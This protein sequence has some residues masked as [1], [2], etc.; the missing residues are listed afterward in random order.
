MCLKKNLV[1][2]Y[3]FDYGS[4]LSSLSL[5]SHTQTQGVLVAASEMLKQRYGFVHTVLQ[6]EKYQDEMSS[7]ESCQKKDQL[8]QYRK[9]ISESNF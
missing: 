8:L 4:F 9:S 1:L 3:C 7:C 2:F 5:D 6:V